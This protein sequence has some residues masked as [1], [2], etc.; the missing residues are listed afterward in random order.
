MNT[1]VEMTVVE[2]TFPLF[3]SKISCYVSL[4]ILVLEL[5]LNVHKLHIIKLNLSSYL[6]IHVKYEPFGNND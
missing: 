1:V 4:L 5:A 6:Y 3:L 2:M